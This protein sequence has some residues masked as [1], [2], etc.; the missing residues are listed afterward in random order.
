MQIFTLPKRLAL[1]LA[2][3]I[4]GGLWY[5]QAGH[6]SAA[7][8]ALPTGMGTATFSVSVPAAGSYRFWAHEYAP[9]TTSNGFYLR[10]DSQ[11]CQ[12]TVGH[13]TIPSSQFTWLDYQNGTTSSKITL[14]LSAGSHTITMAGLD[15]G[16]AIDKVLLL[17]DQTCVP[18]SQG[19]NC[20]NVVT[21][22][23]PSTPVTPVPGGTTGTV[24]PTTPSGV[25]TLPGANSSNKTYYIDGKPITGTQLDTNTL[26][27]GTHVLQVVQQ[28]GDG[29]RTITNQTIIV[30]HKHGLLHGLLAATKRPYVW[31]PVMI[32]FLAA[33]AVCL[34]HVFRP[35]LL[36]AV[37]RRLHVHLPFMPQPL[38][39]GS[40]GVNDQ[41]V[42]G[43]MERT[44]IPH[45][46]AIVFAIVFAAIGAA[47]AIYA[48]AATVSVSYV[49]SNATVS[50]GAVI[51]N[52]GAAI[53]G[54]MVQFEPT[55]ADPT[56]PPDPTP[57]TPPPSGS[58]TCKP[59]TTNCIVHWTTRCPAFP[60]FPNASCTGVPAG[61]TLTA[62]NG[63]VNDGG[64]MVTFIT[65]DNTVIS[66]KTVNCGIVVQAHNVQIINSVVNGPINTLE[67]TSNS[68]AVIN[69][70]VNV[71]GGDDPLS[72]T[73]ITVL[74]ANLNGGQTS[75]YCYANCYME[76][77]W[78]HG[79]G[80]GLADDQPWHLGGVLANDNG[81]DPGG[82]TNLTLIH[83]NIICDYPVNKAD[84]GC[85]GDVNLFGDFGTITHVLIDHNLLGASTSLAYCTYG[86]DS[87]SKGY[88]H[89]DHVV[90]TNNIFGRG[91]NN[92]C[93]A[94][95]PATGFNS[96]GV[97]NVWTN[98]VWDNGGAVT[99]EN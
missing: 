11:Y 34:L 43:T 62:Y 96:A 26:S 97:G 61:T 64:D 30:S 21:T 46:R 3:A 76:D 81:N 60:S 65:A 54:K 2:L 48:L 70:Q 88:P 33:S 39:A 68:F 73:N 28:S 17:A 83:N 42:V 16:V 71:T 9:N 95:G 58:G 78:V 45:R 51:A 90:Y 82:Y 20:T 36:T 25:I 19:D 40:A 57:P 29:K 5:A 6:A 8:S 31:T 59:S 74:G 86:G 32:I 27:D 66:G 35:G 67:G 7:C 13:K 99:P 14:T 4:T 15:Q 79:Q 94:Y 47:T 85:S 38:L 50:N 37:S 93:G 10:V 75:M 1:V 91:S 55:P 23:P 72:S 84:G 53:G 69:S 56:P 24:A 44:G 87:T 80:T 52:N 12:I 89:A 41:I 18:T 63:C 22:P 49:M 98:N 77:S 92:S